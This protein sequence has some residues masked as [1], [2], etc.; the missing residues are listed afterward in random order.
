[1]G[2]FGF[3]VFLAA[4]SLWLG[5][6]IGVA[7]Q[8]NA[9]TKFLNDVDRSI[10]RKYKITC[11]TRAKP[12]TAGRQNPA[13]S[14]SEPTAVPSEGTAA[15]VE[16]TPMPPIPVRKP[17]FVLNAAPAAPG[18]SANTPPMSTQ[19]PVIAFAAAAAI[20]FPRVKPQTLG[21]QAMVIPRIIPEDMPPD[22][23]TGCLQ[24]LRAAG[25]KFTVPASNVDSGS[26]HVQN[27]VN[28][29]AIKARGSSIELPDGPLLNCRFALQFSKWLKESGSPIL[30]AQLGSPLN[31]IATGPGYECRGRNR[32]SS[33]K[34]SEHGFGNAVDIATLRLQDGRL[35]DVAEASRPN[36]ANSAVWHGL[37]ASACGYFTT[38]LGP[39]SNGAHQGH[40]H[41]DLGVHGKNANYRIC[42]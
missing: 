2:K 32:D 38:V 12:A 34:I 22:D 25:A 20:P 16:T 33:A 40:F 9:L 7:A 24:K 36:S 41:F 35:L 14:A 13:A 1:M 31:R 6:G 30:A 17:R 18:K 42:E 29:K 3:I 28:L 27:P 39:G 19:K 8:P 21:K 26:C 5:G 15:T 11:K 4:I 10:C 37:R 23:N